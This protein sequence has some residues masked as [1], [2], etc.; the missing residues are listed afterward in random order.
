MISTIIIIIFFSYRSGMHIVSSWLMMNIAQFGRPS[1][2]PG[3]PHLPLHCTLALHIPVSSFFGPEGVQTV[4]GRTVTGNFVQVMLTNQAPF[5]GG[6]GLSAIT[7]ASVLYL[8]AGLI[9]RSHK[10][11]FIMHFTPSCCAY[12]IGMHQLLCIMRALNHAKCNVC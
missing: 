8:Y 3:T 11:H 6:G 4:A 10:E 2:I 12:N 5:R 9:N 1:T 7:A